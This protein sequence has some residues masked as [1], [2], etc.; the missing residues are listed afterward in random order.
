[1]NFYSFL[2]QNG[3]DNILSGKFTIADFLKAYEQYCKSEGS[4]RL[5][6]LEAFLRKLAAPDR[7][8]LFVSC[9]KKAFPGVITEPDT[10]PIKTLAGRQVD[11]GAQGRTKVMA[12]CKLFDDDCW[13]LA[14]RGIGPLGASQLE[15]EDNRA[16]TVFCTDIQRYASLLWQ[17]QDTGGYTIMMRQGKHYHNTLK[18]L[19]APFCRDL[20]YNLFNTTYTKCVELNSAVD[21]S[22]SI[23][24]ATPH[25]PYE[26]WK[27]SNSKQSQD[28][29]ACLNFWQK[30]LPL[31]RARCAPIRQLLTLAN[32][33]TYNDTLM[34]F[35]SEPEV[36]CL[37]TV[38]GF[39]QY[40]GKLEREK[41]FFTSEASPG[42][43]VQHDFVVTFKLKTGTIALLNQL[44]VLRDDSNAMRHIV[45]HKENEG[46]CYGIHE[47]ALGALSCLIGTVTIKRRANHQPVQP[48]IVFQ[49]WDANALDV[50]YQALETAIQAMLS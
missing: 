43:G 16:V 3:Y 30:E 13:M 36:N 21:A 7:S 37:R 32:V 41:W 28:L 2:S 18:R 9:L 42:N 8:R 17:L 34:R 38:Q 26:N 19:F 47:D 11:F 27:I 15:V 35:V 1:M 23:L 4:G 6:L 49:N 5:A 46:G 44:R 24:Q 33:N 10:T 48:A 29:E 12:A 14:G 31:V 50:Y 39:Q 40:S 20:R 45:Y 22:V 25:K